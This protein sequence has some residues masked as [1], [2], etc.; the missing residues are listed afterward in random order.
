[1]HSFEKMVDYNIEEGIGLYRISSDLIPFGSSPVNGLR[2]W[3]LFR[4]D[5]ERIGQKINQS[6]MRVSFH[7]GQ[8]TVLNSPSE[9]V[10]ER[11]IEDLRYH[12]LMLEMPRSGVRAQNG[13]ARRRDLRRQRSRQ[14]MV[15]RKLQASGRADSAPVDHRKRRPPVHRGRGP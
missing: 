9:D 10:V 12:N 8:Y 15:C 11:A 7:P 6:G 13:A 4:E 5:F 3:E 1:M 14:P 2:W